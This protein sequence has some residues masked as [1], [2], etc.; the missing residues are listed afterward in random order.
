MR[1]IFILSLCNGNDINI[2]IV[3]SFYNGSVVSD[4]LGKRRDVFVNS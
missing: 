3:R 2:E 1:A 4:L